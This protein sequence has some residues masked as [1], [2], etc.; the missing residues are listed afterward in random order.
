MWTYSL[1]QALILGLSSSSYQI[2]AA[3]AYVFYFLEKIGVNIGYSLLLFAGLAILTGI[4]AAII[5][6]SQAEFFYMADRALGT[7]SEPSQENPFSQLRLVF[8]M[9]GMHKFDSIA[10]IAAIASGFV[11]LVFWMSAL[12]PFFSEFFGDKIGESLSDTFGLLSALM[13]SG[14]Y[15]FG[16][17]LFDAAGIKIVSFP[18]SSSSFSFPSS[19]PPLVCAAP[20]V[21]HRGASLLH[22]PPFLLGAAHDALHWSHSVYFPLHLDEQVVRILCSP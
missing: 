1:R 15:I 22:V 6:P 8:R 3:N 5:S 18:A 2:G 20:D 21:S 9:F 17:A 14:I 11:F 4:L 7:S 19:F 16:G 12:L 10:L 13:G